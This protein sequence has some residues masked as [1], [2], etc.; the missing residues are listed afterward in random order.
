MRARH[1]HFNPK[2]A[3]AIAAYDARFL[4]GL[5]DGDAVSTWTSR[6]GTNDATQ[7]TAAAQPTFKTNQINGNPA[8][9]F[10]PSGTADELVISI[11]IPNSLTA[12]SLYNRST[13]GI[14][15]CS[16]GNGVVA[17]RY[18]AYFYV[19]NNIYTNYALEQGWGLDTST[20]NLIMS[21]TKNGTTSSLV[22]KNGTAVGS[23]KV[24]QTSNGSFTRVGRA[25]NV[26]PH[27]GLL[28]SVCLIDLFVSDGL[29]K[30]LEHAT[31]YSYK[32]SCN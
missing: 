32:L 17:N 15:S 14:N 7:S 19:N 11:T 1:R 18:V 6:T 16:I 25:E 12:V 13:T 5:N 27:D 26:S 29:R 21:S 3:G 22:Y 9:N 31:A 20:G 2:H 8:V 23:Q 30:R 24:P 28:A 10:S 4:S